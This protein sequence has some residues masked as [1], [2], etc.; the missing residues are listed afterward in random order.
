MEI[1]SVLQPLG[2]RRTCVRLL[3]NAWLLGYG[4][5][6]LFSNSAAADD[7]PDFLGPHRNSKSAE[8]NLK[9]NWPAAGPPV[10][11]HVPLG[12]SYGAP[13]ISHGRLFHFDRHGASARLTCRDPMTGAQLWTLDHPTAYRELL[14]YSKGPRCAPVVD[15][16][17]VYTF[18]AVGIL[19]CARSEDGARIWSVDSAQEFGVVKNFFGVGSTPIVWKDFVIANLGGSPPGSPPDVYSAGGQVESNG[20]GVVAFD[21]FTG[22]VRWKT[23]DELASYA[24]PVVANIGGRPWCFVFARGGL[25]GLNPENGNVELH[26]AGRARMHES[27]SASTPVVVGNQGFISETYSV[28]SALLA[29]KPGSYEVQWQDD[30]RGRDK[31]LLLHWNTP[32]H[33]E[34]FLYGS[35]GRHKGSAELRSIEWSTGQVQWSVPGLTRCSLTY[36][37]GHLI[38]QAEDGRLHLLAANPKRYELLATV[39]LRDEQGRRMLKEPAWSAP[40]LA[41]GLLYVRGDDRLVCLDLRLSR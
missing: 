8:L 36:A 32:I 12:T 20:S 26:C 13:S 40:V 15:G 39:D 3:Q 10:A 14:G 7:W 38:C 37:E 25:V 2:R 30:V 31:A 1:P 29:V 35:S 28:G 11:W 33:H 16:E 23:S 4:A 17:R 22:E 41:N 19:Q 9:W 5:A 24:S 18:S 6:L 34:G 27:L 21:K